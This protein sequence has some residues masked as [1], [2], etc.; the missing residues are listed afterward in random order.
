MDTTV[1]GIGSVVVAELRAAGYLESTIGQYAKTIK[2]LGAYVGERGGVYRPRLGAEFASMTVSPRTGRFSAQRRLSYRRLVDLFDSYVRTGRVD[3]SVR[4]RGG[5]GPRPAQSALVA[6][7]AAWE[8]EMARRGLAAATREA[9]G[10]V[11]R[12]YLVFLEQRGISDLAGADGGSVLAFLESLLDRWAKSSLFWVVSNFRPFLKFTGRA[13]LV[14]AVNL[15]RVRRSR[16]IVEMLGDADENMVVRA[17]AA[18][19][20]SDRDAAITLLALTT[21]LRACDIIALRLADVDWRG[22]TIALVQQKTGNPLTLPLPA[23]VMGKLAGYVLGER[24][25]TADEHVFVRSLAPHVRLADHASVHQ[26]ITATFRAAGVANMKAG[27]R[28]LRHSAA[29]R[30]LRASV[31][32]PTI[33]AVLGH[34]A[35]DSTS[36]YMNADRERLLQCVL[37]VPAGARR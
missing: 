34:A 20:V 31:P 1:T 22:A 25:A 16:P 11:A 19:L 6:L 2:A 10:R 27:T 28:F 36:V 32:L 13:D 24:P 9:Y 14:A 17:C 12:G 23:L 21:G 4:R 33:S 26:V 15:A 35:E 30:L 18:G 5:G 8:A 29:T 7:D 37:P 3:L